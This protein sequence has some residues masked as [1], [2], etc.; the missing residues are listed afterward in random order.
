VGFS[1]AFQL[2]YSPSGSIRY[3]SD[4]VSCDIEQVL[5]IIAKRQSCAS[6]YRMSKLE[7]NSDIESSSGSSRL[8]TPEV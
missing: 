7:F 3:K 2:E 8:K 5:K 1:H 4:F 6:M